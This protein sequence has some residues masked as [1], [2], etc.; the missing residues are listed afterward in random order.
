MRGARVSSVR[1]LQQ[2]VCVTGFSGAAPA[3]EILPA[4]LSLDLVGLLLDGD[5][6]SVA[7]NRAGR[8]HRCHAVHV[9]ESC[10]VW[11][12]PLR[13]ARDDDGRSRLAVSLR[14]RELDALRLHGCT[15]SSSRS[16]CADVPIS[17]S[18]S[19]G[20][21]GRRRSRSAIDLL[22]AKAEIRP[23]IPLGF[24]STIAFPD[25]AHARYS[26]QCCT[27][28][29]ARVQSLRTTRQAAIHSARMSFGRPAHWSG[30]NRPS[31]RARS[32][33][34][35]VAAAS[36]SASWMFTRIAATR[37]APDW[38]G[39]VE[40]PTARAPIVRPTELPARASASSSNHPEAVRSKN[41]LCW[42]AAI[43]LLASAM[44]MF[45]PLL[46][47]LLVGTSRP[48]ERSTRR[49]G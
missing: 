26:C 48:G 30:S 6:V 12:P 28:A 4:Q 42:Y 45:L 8:R 15:P 27:S 22:L 47:R 33:R 23:S 44:F 11:I 13:R 36:V 21:R 25:R 39:T 3:R 24:L 31:R 14:P 46:R 20:S 17:S 7:L 49:A 9:D 16:N 18:S 19:P 43:R 40:P 35:F 32:R 34:S 29:C 1:N 5:Q 37:S 2:H 41:W 38:I 10:S